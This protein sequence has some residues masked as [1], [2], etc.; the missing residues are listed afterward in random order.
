MFKTNFIGAF[1]SRSFKK[2]V[3]SALESHL[4]FNSLSSSI[5]R[6]VKFKRLSGIYILLKLLFFIY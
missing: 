3:Y 6:A 1:Y 2:S 4:S 5:I